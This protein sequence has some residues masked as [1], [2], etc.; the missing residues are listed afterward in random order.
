MTKVTAFTLAT[1]LLAVSS[2]TVAHADWKVTSQG[3]V[4]QSTHVL[5]DTSDRSTQPSVA[6][7]KSVR[8][9]DST[10]TK[11]R[12]QNSDDRALKL[13][14]EQQK[15]DS[16]ELGLQKELRIEGQN[17]DTRIS[18]ESGER[19]KIQ[20]REFEA[21]T[22]LPISVDL[23]DNTLVVTL[24]SGEQKIKVLPDEAVARLTL[25]KL[26][27]SASGSGV[28]LDEVDGKPVYHIE[29]VTKKRILGIIPWNVHKR[30]QVSAEDGTISTPAA[31]LRERLVNLFAF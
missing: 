18:T 24:P 2:T 9:I 7:E 25:S 5:G 1:L 19:L 29:G 13:R 17:G 23:K 8:Q 15:K 30:L 28:T 21:K 10:K 14:L 4:I 22:N 26:L 11:L 31:T 16:L 3:I 6:L 20:R 12:I 27:D